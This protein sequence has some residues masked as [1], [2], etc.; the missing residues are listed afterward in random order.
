MCVALA[1]MQVV[2]QRG[3]AGISPSGV[4]RPGGDRVRVHGA[5]TALSSQDTADT[6]APCELAQRCQRDGQA[7]L[8]ALFLDLEL[9]S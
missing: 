8:R 4:R 6:P 7:L 1:R 9:E 3:V 2:V 5:G